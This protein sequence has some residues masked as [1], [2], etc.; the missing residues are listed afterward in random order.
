M[1]QIKSF[2]RRKE[3]EIEAIEPIPV[4]AQLVDLKDASP[5]LTELYGSGYSYQSM[6]KRCGGEWKIGTHCAK[7]GKRW[8]VYLPNIHL[9]Q[10]QQR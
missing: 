3:P 10:S 1:P 7:T 8:K 5:I 6:W 2:I 4:G 9:W